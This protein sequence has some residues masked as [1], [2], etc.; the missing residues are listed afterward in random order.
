M[1]TSS[2]EILE[3]TRLQPDQARAILT[4]MESEMEARDLSLLE[5]VAKKED[6][7]RLRAEIASQGTKIVLWMFGMFVA[8]AGLLLALQSHR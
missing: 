4:V 8:L 7:E 1:K 2:L 6:I 3:K 5:R